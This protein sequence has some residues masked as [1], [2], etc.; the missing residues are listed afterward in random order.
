[1]ANPL[2]IDTKALRELLDKGITDEEELKKIM[3][4]QEEEEIPEG[5]ER[6]VVYGIKSSGRLL[7][8]ESAGSMEEFMCR[9]D[10]Y[11][12]RCS[13]LD[14]GSFVILKETKSKRERADCVE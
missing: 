8:I 1:M 14:M 2:K 6:G 13:F 4:K 12:A 7:C 10:K 3:G 5:F 11:I 9:R